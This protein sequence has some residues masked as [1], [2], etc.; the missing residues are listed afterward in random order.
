MKDGADKEFVEAVTR[1]GLG[2][3]ERLP[4]NCQATHVFRIEGR[5]R[6]LPVK[7]M[8]ET[9]SKSWNLKDNEYR[10]TVVLWLTAEKRVFV[11]HTSSVTTPRTRSSSI[12]RQ[13]QVSLQTNFITELV[14]QFREYSV[15]LKDVMEF[16]KY[17]VLTREETLL[18]P[19]TNGL[20]A[21]AHEEILALIGSDH[22]NE[23]PEK[24][25]ADGAFHLGDLDFSLAT[26]T[27]TCTF[28]KDGVTLN[29]FHNTSG[30]DGMILMCRPM[31][32][33]YLG[34]VILPGA[35]A[36]SD[37]KI[38]LNSGSK[39]TPFL[40]PDTQLYTFLRGLHAAVSTS[41]GTYIWPSGAEV[42]IIDLKLVAFSSLCMPHH[43]TDI[44]ERQNNEWRLKVLPDFTYEAPKVQGT[45]VD[46]LMNAVRIQDKPAQII[47]AHNGFSVVLA[48]N[49]G[50]RGRKHGS[51]G[52]YALGDFDALFVFPP[53]KSR[54]FF[55]IPAEA[56]LEQNVIS[57]G[58]SKGKT[59]IVCYLSDYVFAG[60]GRPPNLWTQKY[61]F[62]LRDPEVQSKTASLLERC[63]DWTGLIDMTDGY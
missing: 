35:L 44:V 32:R 53:D 26:Q 13:Y 20:E 42:A 62:D 52:P 4:K 43:A 39:Y 33:L 27:K 19:S 11:C 6:V 57:S 17:K 36:P 25:R 23:T 41:Q 10:G 45:T 12:I 46:V 47:A 61:C 48:K 24:C 56:L 31:T 29:I 15:A 30:Y 9:L 3:L 34:T 21:A 8:L 7:F 55:L 1:S 59:A 54:Y 60:L 16:T 51:K 2:S 63:K 5:E 40:V 18:R 58:D 49:S 50:R 14:E 22:W 28:K 37:F 38:T